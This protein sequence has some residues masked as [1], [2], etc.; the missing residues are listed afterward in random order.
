VDPDDGVVATI[1]LPDNLILR[2]I[3]SD[4]IAGVTRDEF[5]VER[6]VAYTIR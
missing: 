1:D 4:M 3:R 2:D 6:V 5:G